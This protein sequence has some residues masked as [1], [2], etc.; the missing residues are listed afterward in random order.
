MRT[1]P[2]M[3]LPV[4]R[5]LAKLGAD[6]RA[7]RIRRK[8][9]TTLMAERAMITR[10]TLAKIE[11]GDA[12]VSLGLYATVLFLLGLAERL[13]TLA[14]IRHDEVGLALIEEALPKQVRRKRT[15]ESKG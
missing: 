15:S 10:T 12:G 2:P 11:R 3:P 9:P 8:I 14:D 7:A 4:K 5:A 1:A 13:E 6:L